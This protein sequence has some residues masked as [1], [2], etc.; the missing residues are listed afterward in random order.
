MLA[1]RIQSRGWVAP[2]AGSALGMILE[3]LHGQN[4]LTGYFLSVTKQHPCIVRHKQGVFDAGEAGTAT[5][6]YNNHILGQLG[7]Q[8]WHAK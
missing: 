2:R 8:S 7:M 4:Q 1:P 5:S 3:L 6:F